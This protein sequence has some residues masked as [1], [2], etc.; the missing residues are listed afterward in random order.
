MP[1]GHEVDRIHHAQ[2]ARQDRDVGDEADVLH[3][4]LALGAGVLALAVAVWIGRRVLRPV[5]WLTQKAERVAATVRELGLAVHPNV[6]YSRW[7]KGLAGLGGPRYAVIDIGTNSVKFHIGERGADG[8]WRTGLSGL[9]GAVAR[10]V[11]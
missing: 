2:P 6:S 7:L 4:G 1:A 8:A 10:R 9:A 11:C 3:Q 5:E